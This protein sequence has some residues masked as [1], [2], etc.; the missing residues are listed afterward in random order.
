MIGI[1]P[2]QTTT[3]TNKTIDGSQNVFS[4]IPT[5]ALTYSSITINN[6]TIPLGGSINL[7]VEGGEAIINTDTTYSIKAST[8]ATGASL[9]LDAGGS[10]VGTDSVTIEGGGNVTV[11]RV[12][13]NT[14]RISDSGALG[15][16]AL[17]PALA[18]L[19]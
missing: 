11:T 12:D 15:G 2:D 1:K 5:S 3:F 14:I 9:D 19:H 13:G 16:V 17:P 10:G 8:V 6:N 4:N 7:Q 18:P